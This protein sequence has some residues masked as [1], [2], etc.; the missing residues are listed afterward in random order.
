MLAASSITLE[1]ARAR[2]YVSVG[3]RGSI[4]TPSTHMAT[5]LSRPPH[6]RPKAAAFDMPTNFLAVVDMP[7]VMQMIGAADCKWPAGQLM[8]FD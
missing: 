7:D 8:H 6:R 3:S 4:A 5:S 2:G 1:H